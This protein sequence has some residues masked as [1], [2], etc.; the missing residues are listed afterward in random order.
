MH[1]IKRARREFPRFKKKGRKDSFRYPQGIKVRDDEIFLPKIGWVKY[2]KSRD[3]EG[4]IKNA[5]V[6]KKGEHWFVS[7]QTEI[8]VEKSY[9]PSRSS[10]GIDL[11][12]KKFATLSNG[13]IYQA[14]NSFKQKME[15]LAKLQQR[16]AKKKRGSNNFQ[17][18]KKKDRTTPYQNYQ[19]S[20]R[21]FAQS[22]RRHQQKPRVGGA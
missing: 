11:G 10:V 22:K 16:L 8:N 4:T 3:I 19:Y 1:L 14:K 7:V 17:E 21:L 20:N 12:I 15:R 6:S 9:H 2:F 13:H 5:T 18:V